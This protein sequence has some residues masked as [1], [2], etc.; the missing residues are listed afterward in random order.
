MAYKYK[1][2]RKAAYNV[3]KGRTTG[4]FLT[5]EET[6]KATKGFPDAD[7]EGYTTLTEAEDAWF[8]HLE[9]LQYADEEEDDTDPY[10]LI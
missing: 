7:F 3:R 5:W 2:K 4:I 1:K 10:G 9:T 6:Q 8:E